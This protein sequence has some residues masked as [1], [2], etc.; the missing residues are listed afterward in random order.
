MAI[1][2]CKPIEENKYRYHRKSNRL[3]SKLIRKENTEQWNRTG[4]MP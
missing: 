2:Q 1:C 4:E 3:Q